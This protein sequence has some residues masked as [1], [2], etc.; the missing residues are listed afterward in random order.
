MWIRIKALKIFAYHG[1]Y[2][3]EKK[4]GGSFE[5]DVEVALA[6]DVI[7]DEL[8]E[9]VDYTALIELVK[10][11]S[12]GKSYNLIEM[13]A[14]DIC[15]AIIRSQERVNDVTV[16]VRKMTAPIEAEVRYVE[17]EAKATR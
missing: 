16:R 8:R 1:V 6:S 10:T 13:L 17:V 9:T 7:T 11:I 12:D 14:S 3:F 2:D 4:L 5:F 15:T